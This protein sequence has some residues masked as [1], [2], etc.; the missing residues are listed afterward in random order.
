MKTG[1]WAK[2]ADPDDICS[3]LEKILVVA[4]GINFDAAVF[5]HEIGR[6][7]V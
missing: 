5:L 6:A 4:G 1:L 7:H 3:V 2:C